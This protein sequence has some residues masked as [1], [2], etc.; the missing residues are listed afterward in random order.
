MAM[1]AKSKKSAATGAVVSGAAATGAAATGASTGANSGVVATV[2]ETPF[3]IS[4]LMVAAGD[5]FAD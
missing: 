2:T 5:L 1:L 4:D 3:S